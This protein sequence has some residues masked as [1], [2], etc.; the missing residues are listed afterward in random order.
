[1]ADRYLTAPEQDREFNSAVVPEISLGDAIEWISQN[2]APEWVFS[3]QSL[4][5]W[6]GDNGFAKESG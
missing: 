6:A 2:M 1:M 4:R 5:D 3:D